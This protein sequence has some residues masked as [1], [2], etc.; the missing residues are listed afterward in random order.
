MLIFVATRFAHRQ[1]W[2]SKR[3]IMDGLGTYYIP[4]QDT[5]TMW[6]GI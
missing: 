5:K 1:I 6:L 4:I 2:Q 3:S